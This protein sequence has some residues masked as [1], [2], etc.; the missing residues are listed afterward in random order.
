M[1]KI[2]I[3]M[4]CY[5]T[6]EYLHR[7]IPS[8]LNQTLQDIE[9][10]CVNDGST[11]NTAEILQKYA[12]KDNRI[13][14]IT[15]NNQGTLVARKRGIE[16]A[17]GEYC[18]FLDPDDS[19]EL[20][21][22][23]ELYSIIKEQN[24]EILEFNTIIIEKNNTKTTCSSVPYAHQKLH[25]LDALKKMFE[26]QKFFRPWIWNKVISTSL[27]KKILPY[28][29]EKYMIRYEDILMFMMCFLFAT[30]YYN[31]DK[32]Y[33]IYYKGIGNFKEMCFSKF[34]KTLL[35]AQVFFSSMNDFIQSQKLDPIIEKNLKKLIDWMQ[36]DCFQLW[37]RLCPP[38]KQMEG[39]LL[40]LDNVSTDII[41][42]K[43]MLQYERI[44]NQEKFMQDKDKFIQKQKKLIQDKD[45]I[46][47]NK[48]NIIKNKEAELRFYTSLPTNP[49]LTQ[50]LHSFHSHFP[51]LFRVFS[52]V[53]RRTYQVFQSL[54]QNGFWKTYK[55]I[56][57]YICKKIKLRKN[58]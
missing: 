58:I 49:L 18:M 41:L 38:E 30:T 42:K 17:N 31:I 53:V 23:N 52:L 1:P 6:G 40:I 19:Y 57:R 50:A 56:V 2:S 47:Q 4:P 15:Q 3:I 48:D 20:H 36:L 45:N 55:K 28:M 22:C 51:F 25:A 44:Q 32:K 37:E 54:K 5:N 16:H 35:S 26:D 39:F 29:P 13:K 14:I 43:Y 34:Q 9:I 12:D 46:I 7:S 33:H 24:V 8:C 27:C 10:L 21:A 11:D